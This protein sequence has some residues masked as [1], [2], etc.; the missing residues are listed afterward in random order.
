MKPYE[1]ILIKAELRSELYDEIELEVN[2]QLARLVINII[3]ICSL[4][5]AL[6]CFGIIIGGLI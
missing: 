6:V 1:K 5:F 3:L 4:G 2:L